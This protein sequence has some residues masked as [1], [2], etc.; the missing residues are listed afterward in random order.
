MSQLV[1][2][3]SEAVQILSN[4]GDAS[5]GINKLRGQLLAAKL[6]IASGVDNYDI[7]ATVYAS[8]PPPQIQNTSRSV[9]LA[10]GVFIH[11]GVNLRVGHSGRPGLWQP[12]QGREDR[13][14]LRRRH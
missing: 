5:N 10:G 4:N 9:T 7:V 1:E 6:N 3:N 8:R 11:A 13:P 14:R 2:T 12:P